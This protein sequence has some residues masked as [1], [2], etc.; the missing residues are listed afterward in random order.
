MCVCVFVFE[1][2]CVYVKMD[3]T[4]LYTKMF[5]QR[6]LG[7]KVCVCVCVCVGI[8][9]CVGLAELFSISRSSVM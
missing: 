7:R 9:L 2:M 4:I 5:C 1:C 8:C 6:A 3:H